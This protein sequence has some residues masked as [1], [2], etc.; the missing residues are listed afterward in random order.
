M[1]LATYKNIVNLK[2]KDC[3]LYR[4]KNKN[5]KKSNT[6]NRKMPLFM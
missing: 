1:P 5:C 2:S 4:I 3:K 6:K